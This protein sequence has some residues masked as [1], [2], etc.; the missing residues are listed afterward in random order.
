M[1]KPNWTLLFFALAGR[2]LFSAPVLIDD[3]ERA[4]P[5][6]PSSAAVTVTTEA[7]HEDPSKG[8]ALAFSWPFPHARWVESA[9]RNPVPIPA[10]ANEASVAL[11]LDV[12]TPASPAIVHVSIRLIDAKHEM[13]QW[14]AKVPHATTAGWHAL[15]V[16]IDLDNPEAHWGGDNDGRADHPLKL[17][18][19]AVL[20]ASSDVPAGRVLIDNVRSEAFPGVSLATDRFPFLVN[21]T[22]A[23]TCAFAVTNP[24]NRPVQ[25][26][27][28]GKITGFNGEALDV[29]GT[30][31]VPAGGQTR[32]PIILHERRPGIQRLDCTLT[33]DGQPIRCK[34]PFVINDPVERSSGPNDFL[35]GICSHT[36]RSPE[37]EQELEIQAA[38]AAGATV[39]RL[40]DA[41]ARIEPKPGEWHWETQ[42]RLVALAAK[43]GIETQPILGFS[44]SHAISP[45]RRTA[46]AE[47]YKNRQADAWQISLFGAPEEAPWRRYVAAMANRYKGKIRLYEVWNEPDLGFWRG[48]TDEYLLILRAA[49]EELR[50]ADP[51]ARLLTGGFATVLEH[52]GRMK[53][54][55]LQERVLAEASDSFDIHAFHQH[56]AF[57]E[58]QCAV[59]G[60]LQ[61]IRARMTHPRPLYFNETAIS[62]ACI[63]ERSQATTLVKKIAFAMSRG[64]I[65]YTWYDLRNDGE[66]PLDMEHNY[67]LVTARFRPKAAFAAYAEI[68]RRLQ[69][70]RFVGDLNTG[71][72]TYAPVFSSSRNRVVVLWKEDD[73]APNLPILLRCG[74][75]PAHK[76]DIMGDHR[77]IPLVDGV[78]LVQPVSDPYYLELPPGST[79]P[80]MAGTLAQM[81][82]PGET[83]PEQPIDATVAL[84]NPLGRDIKVRLSWRDASGETAART[85]TVEAKGSTQAPLTFKAPAANDVKST[86]KLRFDVVGTPWNG[87]IHHTIP[88]VR[89]IGKA[90]PEGRKADWTLDKPGDCFSF[91]QADPA[92]AAMVWKGPDDLS[93]KIWAW[94]QGDALRLR[95]DVRDDVHV[96]NEK[97]PDIW[98]GD[99]VQL[100]IQHPGRLPLLEIGA[101][102]GTDGQ[103]LRAV[104]TVPTGINVDAEDFDASCAT[105]PGGL[106]YELALP[107]AKLGLT[108]SIRKAGFR[109]NLIVNDN[110]GSLR[111][112]F[113]RIAPGLGEAKDSTAFPMLRLS[114]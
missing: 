65:G 27:F 20:F 83:P 90:A 30:G 40:S 32:L 39:M 88:V 92:L 64:A 31:S 7:V 9:Y 86:A 109:F 108:E 114:D 69:G 98:R 13:F 102:L 10:L 29:S 62:S 96:Q 113:V 71:P 58:F 16:P 73:N 85:V 105:M 89:S 106:R 107:Y 24:C 6:L 110:D 51:S 8:R 53:N 28:K 12:W 45:A 47:A 60:E 35:F 72:G 44:P 42:D 100:A 70:A 95:V 21:A 50:R 68:V 56:G 94:N 18:G 101:A 87:S 74:D 48:T 97:A 59:D 80:D 5:G 82:L 103:M 75:Q 52:Q 99:S 38:A 4:D 111:E 76:A 43:H 26:S 112:G 67:G 3:F 93:A 49:C 104:W 84:A 36:E 37:S 34:A 81:H 19:F 33:F 22:G 25:I 54:Y 77:A 91:C 14:S 78:A 23:Y 17:G 46:Q 1:I 79:L 66:D 11:S 2:S 41:W 55:N 61:R 57:S 63:G 15:T